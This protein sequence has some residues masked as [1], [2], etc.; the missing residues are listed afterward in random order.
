MRALL[1]GGPFVGE[2]EVKAAYQFRGLM[3]E[4]GVR[5]E[6]LLRPE[7]S[8]PECAV[9]DYVGPEEVER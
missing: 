1:R 5:H 9:Y 6:Y 3:D 8:T 2:E 4:A 7:V